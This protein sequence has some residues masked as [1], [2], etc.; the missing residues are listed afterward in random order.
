MLTR[1]DILSEGLEALT[2]VDVLADIAGTE[3]EA[4]WFRSQA[5]TVLA[6][7]GVPE[8]NLE[9]LEKA[10]AQAFEK[11]CDGFSV[12]HLLCDPELDQQFVNRCR[13]QGLAGHATLW[14]QTLMRLRKAGKLPTSTRERRRLTFRSMDAFSFASEIAM[15]L[16]SVDYGLTLDE[17]L[18]SP[19]YAAEFD[20][21]AE[22]F[23]PEFLP[24][25][26]RWA[27]LSIRK[28]ASQSRS[29]G[30]R[31]FAEWLNEKFPPRTPLSRIKFHELDHPGVY[32]LWA[33][34]RPLYVGESAFLSHR[35][36]HVRENPAWQELSPTSATLFLDVDKS[37]NGLQSVL[38]QRTDAV[39][40]WP[41][42][43]AD[44]KSGE[45][46]MN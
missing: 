7:L 28:R 6:K 32:I 16:V 45:P 19:E 9:D 24:Q 39:L 38:L 5:A 26:Y 17:V 30:E 42:L 3:N 1:N 34:N 20:R 23:A 8:E 40:N 41:V 11:S 21:V 43:K 46:L 18:C 29:L 14:N 37:R 33:S 10:I 15:R 35:L 4:S 31:Q 13:S 25:D 44:V 36:S 22:Q 12:D 2:E 27:A